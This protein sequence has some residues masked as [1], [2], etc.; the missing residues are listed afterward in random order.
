MAKTKGTGSLNRGI[1][2]YRKVLKQ[3]G[4]DEDL[5]DDG[6]FEEALTAE[7]P[8]KSE[9]S[10][11]QGGSVNPS[12]PITAGRDAKS[13]L[14]TTREKGA[15]SKVRRVAKFLVLIGTEEASRILAELDM[16]QVEAISREIASIRGIASDEAEEIF[17]EFRELFATTYGWTGAAKGGVEAARK[18]L[19]VAFGREQGETYLRKAIPGGGENPFQF[20]ENFSGGQIS[21]LLRT[22]ALTTA[23]LVIS[24]LPAKL[25]AE[26]LKNMLPEQ[27]AA[28]VK[29]LAYLG[30]TSPDVVERVAAGL[31]EK[32]RR[33]ADAGGEIEHEV[34]GLGALTAILK[35]A[36]V[37]FGEKLLSE[38][39]DEDPDLSQE[40]RDRLY[41][42]DDVVNADDR[43][44]Q[45]KLR[46]M[47]DRDI[48]LLLKGRST[49]F[50]GKILAN[51]SESR[52]TAI[53]E[54]GA[55]LGTVLRKDADVE[56]RKFLDWFRKAR[57]RGDIMLYTDED[58]VR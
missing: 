32:A 3:T 27:K 37:S 21:V 4:L 57:E 51:V 26:V 12:G 36:D 5:I 53:D 44:L 54:E 31:R 14:K 34:D 43:P 2:A 16:D 29:R 15:D 6:M 38:L 50:K 33:F 7:S 52:R 18:L 1:E 55:W 25:S 17:A 58:V 40:I 39:R 10:I 8:A 28:V 30:K 47:N 45:D 11:K 56:G 23:T 35:Q 19:Y 22:E 42:L 9:N 48:A 41:T 49:P 13:P 20:L 46:S 24:R